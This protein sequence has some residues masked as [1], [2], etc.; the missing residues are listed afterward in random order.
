LLRLFKCVNALPKHGLGV[1]GDNY[2]CRNGHDT[3]YKNRAR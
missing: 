3:T 2:N 1:M